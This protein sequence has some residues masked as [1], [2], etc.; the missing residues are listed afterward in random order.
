MTTIIHSNGSKWAGEEPD[1][2]DLLLQRLNDYA[3]D[4]TFEAF[5]NFIDANPVNMAGK[6][7]LPPGWV[8]FFG[9]FQEYSHVFRI[10]TDDVDL[11]ERLTAAIRA[12]QQRPD[13]LSQSDYAEVKAK[14]AAEALARDRLR[15]AKRERE[16]RAVLGLER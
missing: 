15:Q 4:R 16:A 7:L 6:P 10:D 8:N 14:L 5:G 2:I 1:G 13:Y 9:N 11:I 12:N 3:L